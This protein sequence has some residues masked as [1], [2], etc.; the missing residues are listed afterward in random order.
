M[1]YFHGIL[2]LAYWIKYVCTFTFWI[3]YYEFRSLW[4][5]AVL[6]ISC[7][8]FFCYCCRPF[9]PRLLGVWCVAR[10]LKKILGNNSRVSLALVAIRMTAFWLVLLRSMSTIR[11]LTR[12]GTMVCRSITKNIILQCGLLSIPLG[13]N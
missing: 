10:I 9:I 13:K 2:F 4:L 6:G 11:H 8:L 3:I 7:W 1:I 5:S 12:I